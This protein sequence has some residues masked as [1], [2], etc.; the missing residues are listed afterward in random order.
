MISVPVSQGL[1]GSARFHDGLGVASSP[2]AGES[3]LIQGL[4]GLLTERNSADMLQMQAR[5]LRN[6]CLFF[7]ST[8]AEL[9]DLLGD[10]LELSFGF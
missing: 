9:F 1:Q 3:S 10:F 7:L 8:A 2:P 6:T 5:R 4:A